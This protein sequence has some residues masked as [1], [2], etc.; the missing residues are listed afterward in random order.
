M[1]D[2]K[3][4]LQK[5]EYDILR[6]DPRLNKRIILLTLGGSHAYGTQVETSD[7]DVRG[8]AMNS[9]TELFSGRR[10]FEQVVEPKTDTTIY[11]LL[12]IYRTFAPC[13]SQHV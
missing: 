3:S 9:L 8:V 12:K 13:Q 10:T 2:L 6:N 11:S 7:V 4:F 1:E 5:P